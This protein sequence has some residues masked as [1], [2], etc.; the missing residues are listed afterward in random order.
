MNQTQMKASKE[1]GTTL[2]EVLVAVVVLSLGL[3]GLAALQGISLRSSSNAF[4][5]TQATNLSYEIL[6]QV[7]ANRT[8][9]VRRGGPSIAQTAL[10]QNQVAATLPD[11]VIEITGPGG[12]PLAC[13]ADNCEVAVRIRWA[14]TVQRGTAAADSTAAGYD[15]TDAALRWFEMDT[16]I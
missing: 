5:R 1:R 14:D 2:I 3:L 13:N 10:W 11:G 16:R 4:N 12:T 6:D 7:R 8:E 9:I 15:S